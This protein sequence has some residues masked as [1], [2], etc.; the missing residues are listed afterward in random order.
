MTTTP[1]APPKNRTI[2]R[3]ATIAKSRTKTPTWVP[4]VLVALGII[5]IW[6]LVSYVF[7]DEKRRFLLPPP[8]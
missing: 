8:H 4:P 6:Y 7:L 5:A 1:P 3:P 2:M